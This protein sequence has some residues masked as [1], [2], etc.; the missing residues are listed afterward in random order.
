M[1]SRHRS[2]VV[3]W[4]HVPADTGYGFGRSGEKNSKSKFIGEYSALYTGQNL[5]KRLICLG[6][7]PV[8]LYHV[9]IVREKKRYT[10]ADIHI[11]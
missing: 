1:R 8:Q 10:A 7:F 4:P 5:H 9:N 2:V 3:I 11:P 6:Q